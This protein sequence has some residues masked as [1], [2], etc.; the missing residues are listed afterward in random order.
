MTTDHERGKDPT[1]QGRVPETFHKRHHPE[2]SSAEEA[3][4]ENSAPGPAARKDGAYFYGYKG[5]A[6]DA[7]DAPQGGTGASD[8]GNVGG[9]SMSS[10]DSAAAIN[11]ST[12]AGTTKS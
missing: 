8:D 1:P 6:Q 12:A 3:R 7:G 9:I 5:S 2:P 4:F 10:A 11:S